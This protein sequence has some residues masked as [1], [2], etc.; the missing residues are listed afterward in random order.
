MNEP[1][2]E[3]VVNMARNCKAGV[4]LVRSGKWTLE[5]LDKWLDAVITNDAQFLNDTVREISERMQ[6][7]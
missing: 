7:T 6:Y 1:F 3:G 2:S 5:Q 4:E